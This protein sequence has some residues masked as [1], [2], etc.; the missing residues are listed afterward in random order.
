MKICIRCEKTKELTEF[1]KARRMKQGV[2]SSCKECVKKAVYKW[3]KTAD[4]IRSVIETN[5]K[6][7]L[8]RSE[9]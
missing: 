2:N 1:Y 6:Y 4:G 8:K 7:Y 9:K 5:R 3:R